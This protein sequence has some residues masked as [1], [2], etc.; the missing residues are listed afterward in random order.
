MWDERYSTEDYAYGKLPNDFLK[1]N[2]LALPRGRILSI[3]EG[4]GR[5]A[6]FLARHGYAVTAMDGSSVGLGKARQLAAEHGVSIETVCADL[7]DFDFGVNQWEGIVCIFCPLP[8]ALRQTVFQRVTAAL[9][10]GGVF[11]IEA[12]RPEQ[13]Q[14][15]TGGGKSAD[16]MTTEADLR[17][18]LAGLR[19]QHLQSLERS[20][21]E[22]SYHTGLGAVVQAIAIKAA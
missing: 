3:A 8:A 14:H 15:G 4:E 10:P 20:V 21:I 11:L 6:V 16:T 5:N 1:E 19:F 9:K 17:A 12:Y 2:L 13:L 7:E 22:G 18:G